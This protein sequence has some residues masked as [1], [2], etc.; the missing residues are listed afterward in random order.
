MT[1]RIAV[2]GA[3]LAA[4]LW[5]SAEAL[6]L[7]PFREVARQVFV[8]VEGTLTPRYQWRYV[9]DGVAPET[10]VAVLTDTQTGAFAITSVPAD[11]CRQR[12]R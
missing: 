1:T 4:A 6:E 12:A 2:I 10:C 3:A 5:T 7:L 9:T 8:T 11:S